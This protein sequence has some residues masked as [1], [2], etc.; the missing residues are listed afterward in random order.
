ML[1]DRLVL[2]GKISAGVVLPVEMRQEDAQD[3]R[4]RFIDAPVGARI[5]GDA[6]FVPAVLAHAAQAVSDDGSL[7][8]TAPASPAAPRFFV[9]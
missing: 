9:G 1:R 6:L 7:V 8:A 3:R 4:L 5:H 2:P